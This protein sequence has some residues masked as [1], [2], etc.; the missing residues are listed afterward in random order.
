MNRFR[1]IVAWALLVGSVVGW[2][3][4][5][6][7]WAKD[8]PQFILGLSFLAIILTAWDILQ[9]SHVRNE[10]EDGGDG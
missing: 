5:A 3:L 10:Q 4:S 9:T 8:E 6:I 1:I 7:T 2:P